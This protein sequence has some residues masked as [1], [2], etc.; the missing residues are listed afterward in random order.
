MKPFGQPRPRRRAF[1]ARHPYFCVAVVAHVLVFGTLYRIGSVRIQRAVD[2]STGARI[3]ASLEAG[4][5]RQMKRYVDHLEDLQRRLDATTGA[6]ASDGGAGAVS[7]AASGAL[8]D[9]QA[10]LK[11]VQ[12]MTDRI[13]RTE[14]AQRAKEL[15]RLL[16]ISPD[17]A[18]ATVKAEDQAQRAKQ[19]PL[20]A[21]PASAAA[22][23][24]QRARVALERQ[25]V[26]DARAE[27]GRPVTL[28]HGGGGNQGSGGSGAGQGNGSGA[29]QG[30]GS[31]QSGAGSHGS[32][33]GAG[34]GS[35]R[36]SGSGGGT[37]GG[38]PALAGGALRTEAGFADPRN[39]TKPADLPNV[40]I[41]DVRAGRG[42]VIGRGGEFANR[43]YLDQWYVV[44]PFDAHGQA[45]LQEAYPP[46]WGVDLD[47]V[48]RGKGGALL[49]WVL[50]DSPSYPFIPPDRAEDAVFYAWTE[51]RVAQD[52]TVWMDIGADDDSKLWVNDQLV[53]ASGDQDKAWYHRPFY[54]LGP[55]IAAFDLVEGRRRVTLHA[56]RNTLLFKLYNGIDLMFLSVVITP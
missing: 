37:D 9:A 42:R 52:T 39:Y 55:A 11:R 19:P 51:V 17:Q 45:S 7:D 30:N 24:E 3:E 23:L 1:V 43:L 34:G 22:Q 53:W 20:P 32:G 10:S 28:A 40:V 12:A 44:G 8:P 49:Q 14:Q 18:L 2:A 36:G 33:N 25:A 54:E 4:R 48:Y 27:Q 26:R 46:E 21:D 50:S 47:A 13:E 6:K 35:G 38:D 31:A 16:R 56:G 15:A 41:G 29:G 5:R